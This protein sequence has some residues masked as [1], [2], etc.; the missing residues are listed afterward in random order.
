ML[1]CA[2]LLGGNAKSFLLHSTLALR[3]GKRKDPHPTPGR[4]GLSQILAA[5][6]VK[7]TGRRAT[8][9]R[10]LIRLYGCPYLES[11]DQC[12]QE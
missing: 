4:S 6:A 7:K 12:Q 2:A 11:N 10:P 5:V 3:R 9:R 1:P 8:F